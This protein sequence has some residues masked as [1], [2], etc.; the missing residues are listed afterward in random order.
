MES[1]MPDHNNILLHLTL[2]PAPGS[3][4]PASDIGPELAA[5]V[6]ALLDNLDASPVAIGATSNELTIVAPLPL[7]MS[8][9]HLVFCIK[10]GTERWL[11]HQ[12]DAKR[13]FFW[14]PGFRALS[15]DRTSLNA[16]I[17]GLQQRSTYCEPA[18]PI[19]RTSAPSARGSGQWEADANCY[20]DATAT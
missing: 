3:S 18:S 8:T 7:S 20:D 13:A 4:L 11:T 1:L 15:I 5:Y 6:R 9:S 16:L 19:A 17:R 12:C 10:R 2:E 14:A